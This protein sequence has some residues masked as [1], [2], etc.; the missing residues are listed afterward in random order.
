[1]SKSTDRFLELF[2]SDRAEKR[3]FGQATAERVARMGRIEKLASKAVIARQ[4]DTVDRLYFILSGHLKI[5]SN[6]ASG[7]EHVIALM[8]QADVFGVLGVFDSEIN[9]HEVA[10]HGDVTVLTLART[11]ALTLFE[12]DDGFRRGMF[13]LMCRRMRELFSR[14]QAFALS[15][16][17]ARLAGHLETLAQSHGV[18]ES[19]GIIIRIPRLQDTLAALTGISRQA[20]NRHLKAF[21]DEGFIE[22][23]NRDLLVLDLQGLARAAIDLAE[24]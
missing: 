15:P 12:N 21:E 17:R 20:T 1:M 23:Q 3:L 11:K 6:N 2:Q 10:A 5:Y 18:P 4:A 7:R 13:S 19:G 16:P 8:E 9:P 14:L 22:V 24:D